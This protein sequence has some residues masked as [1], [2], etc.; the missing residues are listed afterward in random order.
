VS[1]PKENQDSV[2]TAPEGPLN[3]TTPPI[4]LQQKGAEPSDFEP[5]DKTM[6]EMREFLGSQD[7]ARRRA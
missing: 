4:D 5:L 1:D 2:D 6:A 7:R 3:E